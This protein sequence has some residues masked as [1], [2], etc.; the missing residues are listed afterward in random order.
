[1]PSGGTSAKSESGRFAPEIF[2]V[3]VNVVRLPAASRRT[4]RFTSPVAATATSE[5]D[6][7][8]PGFFGVSV[9]STRPLSAGASVA[10]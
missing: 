7:S 2:C 4:S 6:L 9:T 5:A 8:A 3:N 1:M 10:S